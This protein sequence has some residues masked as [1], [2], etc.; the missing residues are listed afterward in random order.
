MGKVKGVAKGS[1]TVYAYAQNGIAKK[2]KIKVDPNSTPQEVGDMMSRGLHMMHKFEDEMHHN[3]FGHKLM[4]I[5]KPMMMK[6]LHHACDM[7]EP[8]VMHHMCHHMDHHHGHQGEHHCKQLVN[9][10]IKGIIYFFLI[11]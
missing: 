2:I 11:K 4:M 5:G 3:P 9:N 1:C 7:M 6:G 8:K 10:I